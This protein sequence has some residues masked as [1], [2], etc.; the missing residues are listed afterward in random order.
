MLISEA[1]INMQGSIST[2]AVSKWVRVHHLHRNSL[3]LCC[4]YTQ[5]LSFVEEKKS[6]MQ[7]FTFSISSGQ[8]QEWAAT[9]QPY[10]K[11]DLGEEEVKNKIRTLSPQPPPLVLLDNNGSNPV[12]FVFR[13]LHQSDKKSEV[14]KYFLCILTF[15]EILLLHYLGNIRCFLTQKLILSE[16]ERKEKET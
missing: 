11:E 6:Q 16:A 7:S 10:W 8:Q 15:W 1:R 2:P 4:L 5:I 3:V 12:S 9:D 13:C 14:K